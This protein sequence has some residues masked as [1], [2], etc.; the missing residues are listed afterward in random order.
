M[1]AQ[2]DEGFLYLFIE[3]KGKVDFTKAHYLIGLDTC[4]SENG[5]FMFPLN[6]HLMAPVGLKFL[7]HLAGKDRSRI[8]VCKDYDKYLNGERKEIRP[9]VS[10][11]GEWV[12]MQNK[13][14]MRRISKDGKSFFPSR[15]YS[16]SNL[17]FGSLDPNHPHYDSLADFYFTNNLI[18]IRLPWSLIQFT[19]PSSKRVLWMDKDH[20]VKKTDGIN[21]LVISYYPEEGQLFARKTGQKINIS[22]SFPERLRLENIKKY[23]W[24]EWHTPIYHTYLKA[25]YYKYRETLSSIS[26]LIGPHGI[27]GYSCAQPGALRIIKM[28]FMPLLLALI[29]S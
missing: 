4:S 19:D 13:T 14:N 21:L 20:Q 3:T 16:M 5:G 17:R 15:V 1:L 18:E 12:I 6:T 25:S 28:T 9:R 24:E 8:L 7:V 27:P 29:K 22:D 10:D 11:Q 2:H 23:T 26:G